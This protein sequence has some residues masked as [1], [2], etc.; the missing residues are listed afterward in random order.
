MWKGVDV[1]RYIIFV[2]FIVILLIAVGCVMFQSNKAAIIADRLSAIPDDA[3][4]VLPKDDL[5]PPVLQTSGE[6]LRLCRRL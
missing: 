6:V 2:M 5:F 4:K 3:V 1:K